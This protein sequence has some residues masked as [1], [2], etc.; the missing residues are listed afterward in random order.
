MSRCGEGT[1]SIVEAHTNVRVSHGSDNDK[2]KG[3]DNAYS[4]P[5]DRCPSPK[6][7]KK[8]VDR[9]EVDED[10]VPRDGP[11]EDLQVCRKKVIELEDALT[12]TYGSK[13]SVKGEWSVN[14]II[15]GLHVVTLISPK[16]E[17]LAPK[18]A[19]A[20]YSS[21]RGAFVRDIIFSIQERDKKHIKLEL[22]KRI[23][24]PEGSEAAARNCALQ[25]MDKAW[26]G[27]KNALHKNMCRRTPFR[28]YGKMSQVQW[29]K[30]FKF[31]TS[32]EEMEKSKKMT[33]LTKRYKW[34]HRL[35]SGGYAP[36]IEQWTKD[37]VELRKLGAPVPMEKMGTMFKALARTLKIMNNGKVVL[38]D[39][40]LQKV[41]DNIEF[42]SDALENGEFTPRERMMCFARCW[43]ILSTGVG[44]EGCPLNYVRNNGSKRKPLNTINGWHI[45]MT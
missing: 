36:K 34:L 18:T 2:P 4:S 28:K 25:T 10:Y 39:P 22:K 43:S 16:E 14:K 11:H 7:R 42:L 21:Q 44:F 17:P 13:K 23:Q 19:R 5:S 9:E 24:F 12:T 33:E 32:P 8:H 35:R 26:H 30:L 3:K 27:W 41:A 40:E 37:K 45:R 38:E 1:K 20:K 29:D 31:E 15:D 6:R